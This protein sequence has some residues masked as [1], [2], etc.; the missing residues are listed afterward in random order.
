MESKRRRA[1]ARRRAEAGAGGGGECPACS[2]HRAC[3][4]V[5]RVE[6]VARVKSAT[7]GTGK[8]DAAQSQNP[9]EKIFWRVILSDTCH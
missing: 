5:E 3:V 7:F 4:S 8:S 6:A 9:R 1:T 2:V